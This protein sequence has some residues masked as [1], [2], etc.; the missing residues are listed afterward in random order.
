MTVAP[1]DSQSEVYAR[2]FEE[3]DAATATL[4]DFVDNTIKPLQEVD[5]AFGGDYGKWYRFANSLKLRLAMRMVYADAANAR[6][7]AE[8]AV[9]D[10]VMIGN[11]DIA[12]IKSTNGIMV[13][14]PLNVCWDSYENCRIGAALDSY[15]N[16]YEDPRRPAFMLLSTESEDGGYHGVYPGLA[17]GETKNQYTAMSSPNVMKDTPVQWMNYAEVCFLRAEGAARGW[18]MGGTAEELYN[19]GIK[20]SFEQYN[21][22]GAEAYSQLTDKKPAGFVDAA[23][24]GKDKAAVSSVTIKWSESATLETKLERIITQKWIAMWPNGQEAWSEYRRT[25]YPK[26]FPVAKNQSDGEIDSNKQI[27]RM[28]YPRHEYSGNRTEVMTAVKLLNAESKNPANGDTGG[29]QVWWDR[30]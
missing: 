1:Y 13:Y 30:K 3:L 27:R 5:L 10:G 8:Q 12:Q 17:G 29:V 4:R 2:F 19:A 28:V 21:I 11:S 7:Y 23:L 15:M 16:G 20:A 14:N 6:T 25:G 18:E 24:T 26:L 9:R 22:A